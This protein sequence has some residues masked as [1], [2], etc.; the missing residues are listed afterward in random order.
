MTEPRFETEATWRHVQYREVSRFTETYGFAGAAGNVNLEGVHYTPSGRG[1]KTLMIF[2]HPSSTLQLLPVTRALPTHGVHVLCAGSRYPKNDSALI[3]EKILLDIGAWIR[4]AKEDWGYDKIVLGGWSGGGALSLFYQAQA[5]NPT[6]T[7][8]PAGD[9]VDVAG[10]A[11]IPADAIT[12]QAAHLSRARTLTEWMDASVRDELDPDDRDPELDIY[13]P[14]N[15]PPFG[16]GFVERYRAAQIARNRRITAWVRQTLEDLRKRGGKEV[17]RGFVVH[18]TMADPRFLDPAIDPN[19]RKPNWCYLGDPETVNSGPVG[20]GRFSTLRS[21]L[22]QWSYDE[23][24]ADGPANAAAISVPLLAIENSADD[25]VPQPHTR[26][27]FEAA[28]TADKEHRV[29]EGATHYYLDQ[30][31]QMAE[32]IGLTLGWLRERNLLEG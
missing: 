25:A 7:D 32:A 27:I 21:W 28:G 31:E 22:S 14:A 24:R 2:M 30:P 3:F 17:E 23:S 9:P 6:I 15:G 11:L 12:F 4:T 18:R 1:S 20:I 10:A 19:D 8:T 5:E 16:A 26:A 29:I 13:N